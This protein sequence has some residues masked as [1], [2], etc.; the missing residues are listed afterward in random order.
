MKVKQ[1]PPDW[2]RIWG[3]TNSKEET[4]FLAKVSREIKTKENK[5]NNIVVSGLNERDN[6]TAEEKENHDSEELKA[7]L[8]LIGIN[9]DHVKRRVRIRKTRPSNKPALLLVEFD[10]K[11]VQES[12]LR[13]AKKLKDEENMKNVFINK[14][15]TTAEREAEKEMRIERDNRNAA[16]DSVG[17]GRL[18]YGTENGRQYY[19]GI[20]EKILV[21]CL[22]RRP[23]A[24]REVSVLLDNAIAKA[25]SLVDSGK[26]TGLI[27]AGDL[28]HPGL[29]W[30][31][32]GGIS[33]DH[34]TAA[35][36]E[37]LETLNTNFLVQHVFDHTYNK[38]TLDLI[39]TEDPSRIH[40]VK[41]NPPLGSTVK[42]NLHASLKW[43]FNLRASTKPSEFLFDRL[44]YRKGNYT[45]LK[46]SLSLISWE[47]EYPANN[48]VEQ[49]YTKFREI[50]Q[51]KMNEFIPKVKSKINPKPRWF[52]GDLKK[53]LREKYSSWFKYKSSK[54]KPIL[55]QQFVE[56][57]KSVKILI[58]KLV[59]NYELELIKKCKTD[60]KLIYSY[61]N[62]QTKT[63][64]K[65]QSIELADGE[66]SFEGHQIVERLSEYFSS[67]F[68]DESSGVQ[69]PLFA[70]RSHNQ[71][72]FDVD[73]ITLEN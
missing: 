33:G 38:S 70:K 58:R 47:G 39:I 1:A 46:S 20:R 14:D 34:P 41:L 52:T 42:N 71:C 15:L 27:I 30:T 73:S 40:A 17:E 36:I 59:A 43:R 9:S 64:S 68:C 63:R 19:W 7:V 48:D 3:N 55:K 62:S 53:A 11:N 13:G 8:D 50:F 67:V 12:A 21:G 32:E 49:M 60:P 56:K 66:V 4:I 45:N 35:S 10:K 57:A 65:I 51:S 37:F 28:N 23:N 18:R 22:Y 2:S 5:E 54:N 29:K 61:I 16:L 69:Y 6:G 26:Y 44:D 31:V 72:I 24:Q 25:K